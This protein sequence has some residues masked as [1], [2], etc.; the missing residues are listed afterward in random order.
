MNHSLSTLVLGAMLGATSMTGALAADARPETSPM[1]RVTASRT[2]QA[3]E[4]PGE[5]DRV[6]GGKQ[7]D[8]GAWPFQVALLMSEKLD[9]SPASQPNAQFCGGSLIAPGWVLTAAHCLY[10]EG[11][12]IPAASVT[13]LSDATNL[14]EGARHRVAAVIVHEGYSEATLDNDIGLLQLADPAAA[15]IIALPSGAT[16]DTGKVTVTGWGMMGDGTFPNDL[17]QADLDLQTNAACNSGIKDIYAGD[18]TNALMQFSGRMRYSEKGVEGARS[19]IAADM[20]DPLTA[21]MICAGTPTGARDAC[22]GD[23][24][25]PLFARGPDGRLTQVGVVSWGEGPVDASM[26]C[27]HANAYGVYTRV[28]NYLDWIKEKTGL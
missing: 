8:K 1:S 15:R 14:G 24:G 3:A 23:S 4:R 17:M 5:T 9:E 12:A 10:D 26:A 28:S 6:V 19:A 20:R 2:A 11:A 13:V 25:G 16:E 27:G 22:N 21:N 18:L 7:A